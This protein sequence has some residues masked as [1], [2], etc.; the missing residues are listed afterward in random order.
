MTSSKTT[1]IA[2]YVT[3]AEHLEFLPSNAVY[4]HQPTRKHNI[5]T[6]LSL[7]KDLSTHIENKPAAKFG[8]VYLPEVCL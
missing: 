8:R 2:V 1:S 5:Y 6:W 7:T 4:T 3:D